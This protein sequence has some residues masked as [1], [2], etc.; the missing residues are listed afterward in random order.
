MVQ[1]ADSFKLTQSSPNTDLPDHVTALLCSDWLL[2]LSLLL[3]VVEHDRD[4]WL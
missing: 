3:E 4:I 2:E 1:A